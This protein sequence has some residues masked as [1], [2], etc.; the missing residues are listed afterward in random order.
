MC[1]GVCARVVCVCVQKSRHVLTVYLHL[2]K[3][4]LQAKLMMSQM[5]T[6]STESRNQHTHTLPHK[7][8]GTHQHH[9]GEEDGESSILSA[10]HV[11]QV[12]ALHTTESRH[13]LRATQQQHTHG[14]LRPKN[15]HTTHRFLE[16]GGRNTELLRLL[17]KQL[18]FVSSLDDFLCGVT[19]DSNTTAQHSNSVRRPHRCCSSWCP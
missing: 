11:L 8:L 9:D 5:T 13:K 3:S 17:H 2:L 14:K 4:K 16:F 15:S 10:H 7:H 1:G 12:L 18:H 19:H 6:C